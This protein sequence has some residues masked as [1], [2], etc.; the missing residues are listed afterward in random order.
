MWDLS[1]PHQ[2]SNCCP[3]QWKFVVHWMAGQVPQA[4]VFFLFCFVLFFKDIVRREGH[5]MCHQLVDFF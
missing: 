3:L 2:G 4:R 1:F 5:R